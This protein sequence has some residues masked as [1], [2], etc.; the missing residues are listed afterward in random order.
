MQP[1][2]E[3]NHKHPLS[4]AKHHAALRPYLAG[5][6]MQDM[7]LHETRFNFQKAKKDGVP[8]DED[9]QLSTFAYCLAS[10]AQSS[11]R[12]FSVESDLQSLL[13]ATSLEGVSWGDV[14]FPFGSF[15]VS[16]AN[17]L[18][19]DNGDK[20]SNIL[21]TLEEN[22]EGIEYM[23]F[24]LI[25]D[26]TMQNKT[27][28]A[29]ERADLSKALLQRNMSKI[30]KIARKI[31]GYMKKIPWLYFRSRSLLS[32]ESVDESLVIG[33][34]Q[35]SILTA[36]VRIVVGLCLYMKTLPSKTPHLSPWTSTGRLPSA[37]GNSV[38]NNSQV[39]VVS[40]IF[41]LDAE[42]KAVLE[43]SQDRPT[44]SFGEKCCHFRMG[45]WCRPPRSPLDA[46]K[47]VWRRPTIVRKDKLTPGTLPQG[48][49]AVLGLKTQV[50]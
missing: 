32:E 3:K 45:A 35:Q 48:A 25:A 27:L 23:W 36:A 5:P 43:D 46:K 18:I 6:V 9:E 28:L 22:K 29:P 17:P 13:N 38:S 37:R 8:K 31:D 15:L 30:E 39:C 1:D 20:F 34:E 33:C 26:K 11:R 44:P 10:W 14:K 24:Y 40:S 4:A 47:T 42:E 16:L 12:V 50:T 41:R 7:H 2:N 21:F 19:D 49:E